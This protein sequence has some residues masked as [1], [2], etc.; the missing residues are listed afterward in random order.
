M[1]VIGIDPS[2]QDKGHGVAIYIDGEL[3]ELSMMLTAD[4]VLTLFEK[5][6]KDAVYSI[7]NVCANNATWSGRGENQRHIGKMQ[8][9][10]IELVRWLDRFDINYVLHKVSKKWK[11]DEPVFKK[12]TG[13]SKQSNKDTRSAA[14]FGYL[15]VKNPIFITK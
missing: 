10:M 8:Q 3:K 1:I 15:E 7:E 5:Y 12:I 6:G 11:E 2:S 13:W 9:S 14:Y 4:I